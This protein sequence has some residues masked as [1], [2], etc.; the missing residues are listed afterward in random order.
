MH[1]HD[2]AI[3]DQAANKH[4]DRKSINPVPNPPRR[5]V[6]FLPE[7]GYVVIAFKADNP[8]SWL[9]HCHIASHASGGLAM[10]V[11]EDR[12]EAATKWPPS[13]DEWET[14]H[15]LCMA[16]TSWCATIGGCNNTRFQDDSGI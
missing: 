4:F 2:F 14:A 3:I 15:K 10:Q 6:V 12:K 13:S 16:W 7:E 9:V 8:G 1:G 5:D 11:L